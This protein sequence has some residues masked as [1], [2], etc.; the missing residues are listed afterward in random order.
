[1][2][3]FAQRLLASAENHVVHRQQQL[4]GADAQVQALVVD[5]AVVAAG[6]HVDA[7]G[8]Q[9]GAVNPARGLAE[10]GTHLGA[11]ALQ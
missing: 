3:Q 11:L 9:A 5:L 1:M 8:E 4:V 10:T 6:D 7:L 2:Q